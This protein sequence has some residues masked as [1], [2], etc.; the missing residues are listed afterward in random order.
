LYLNIWVPI[1]QSRPLP[2][3]VWLYGG[4]FVEGNAN[5]YPGEYLGSN[6]LIIVTLNYRLGAFGYFYHPAI[7]NSSGTSGFF[8]IQDQRAAFA[9]VKNNIEKFGGDPNKIT[10]SGESAGAIS[11]CIHLATPKS[12]G[13][14]SRALMESGFCKIKTPEESLPLSEQIISS[15]GCPAADPLSCLLGKTV[16]QIM[17]VVKVNTY[18]PTLHPY[19]ITEQPFELISKNQYNVVPV[20]AGINK[21][22]CSMWFCPR[23]ENY[24]QTQYENVVKACYPSAVVPSLLQFYTPSKYANPNAAL[25]A[26]TS[27]SIFKCPTKKL[28]ETVSQSGK[29][30]SFT[31]SF[32]HAP[33][34]KCHGAEHSNELSYIWWATSYRSG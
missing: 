7:T 22:E 29:A 17:A 4:G 26:M 8:G 24:N 6:D 31:Y 2:V 3:L 13:L 25:I 21:D 19:E 11:V 33:G 20:L 18:F 12:A 1:N 34:D 5:G 30:D 9:W 23:Y 32:D 14:F 27:D 28:V 15:L 10:I 16:Q